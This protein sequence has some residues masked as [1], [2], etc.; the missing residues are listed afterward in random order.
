MA[1]TLHKGASYLAV[2]LD[3]APTTSPGVVRVYDADL[4]KLAE[5]RTSF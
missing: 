3:G 4:N 5:V 2:A 1:Y